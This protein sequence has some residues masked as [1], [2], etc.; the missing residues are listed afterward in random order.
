MQR[1]PGQLVCGRNP[2]PA[3]MASDKPTLLGLADRCRD[4]SGR[5][6]ERDEVAM[7]GFE[8]AILAT[9]AAHVLDHQEAQ[10]TE[11]VDPE[12]AERLAFQYLARQLDKL[13]FAAHGRPRSFSTS[14][15]S[16]S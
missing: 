14:S 9:S 1:D 12:R 15:Q 11:P 4:M 3:P 6:A 7:W 16:V 5:N 10:H 13:L 2:K 8:V